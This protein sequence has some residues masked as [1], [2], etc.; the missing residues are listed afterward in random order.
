MTAE[1]A[2]QLILRGFGVAVLT[3]AGAWRI[4][5]VGVTI[6]PL[7]G[8][9]LRVRTSMVARS[10]NQSKIVSDIVRGFVTAVGPDRKATQFKLPL[11]K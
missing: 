9:D 3:R 5:R 11:R 10:D 1:D 2:L 8:E 7:D 4:Q 6:R